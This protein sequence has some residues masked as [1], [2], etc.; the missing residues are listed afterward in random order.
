MLP[1]S[2]PGLCRRLLRLLGGVYALLLFFV[3]AVCWP[4]EGCT[5]TLRLR[6]SSQ[7]HVLKHAIFIRGTGDPANLE[8]STGHALDLA[9][10]FGGDA[11]AFGRPV[12]RAPLLTG[13]QRDSAA[14]A[15]YRQLLKRPGSRYVN[16]DYDLY[17]R[18]QMKAMRETILTNPR[19]QHIVLWIHGGRNPLWSGPGRTFEIASALDTT[20][21]YPI[22]IN[23]EGSDV[24]AYWNH[25]TYARP[26]KRKW[27][28]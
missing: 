13:S 14:R 11:H 24:G 5:S 1:N 2:R 23:W 7:Y 27:Y 21:C 9:S 8:D 6:D 28:E 17:L 19:K 15:R 22:C 18:L 16:Y 4:A 12:T 26:A 10:A 20:A 25:L 3:L